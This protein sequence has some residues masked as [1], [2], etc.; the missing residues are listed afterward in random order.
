MNKLSASVCAKLNLT[1][2]IKGKRDDSYH[3][4]SMIMQSVDLCDKVSVEINDTGEVQVKCGELSGDDNLAAKAAKL[5]FSLKGLK[6]GADITIEKHIP[7]CGGLAGGSADAA[8]TLAVL[9]RLCGALDEAVRDKAVLSLGA[10]VPFAMVGGTAYVSGVGEKI[11]PIKPI[12]NCFFVLANGGEKGSTGEMFSKFDSLKDPVRPQTDKV[13][14]AL[15]SGDLAC[16]AKLFY[17]SFEQLWQDRLPKQIMAQM[18]ESGCLGG[19]VSGSGPT[20]F[21]VFDSE[22]KANAC[23]EYLSEFTECYVCRPTEKSIFFE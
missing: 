8:A 21:G 14:T 3:D 12:A 2:D 5:Y 20:F 23:A 7:V 9:E 1:L 18:Y 22:C 16:A 10:D 17:N 19:T 13:L 15:S 11:V 4:L 6:K